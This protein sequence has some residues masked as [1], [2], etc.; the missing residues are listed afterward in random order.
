MPTV[1][2]DNGEALP[3]VRHKE[4]GQD[5]PSERGAPA[6]PADGAEKGAIEKDAYGV[7]G[8]SE[9]AIEALGQ[10][11][12][13]TPVADIESVTDPERHRHQQTIR[14]TIK[15]AVGLHRATKRIV[16]D[17]IALD[18]ASANA[19]E[20]LDEDDEVVVL[21]PATE[22]VIA[23]GPKR[24]VLYGLC[25][26]LEMAMKI[27]GFL[28]DTKLVCAIFTFS[29]AVT[30]LAMAK[31]VPYEFIWLGILG[32]PDMLR[33]FFKLNM[34]AVVLILHELDFWVPF[35]TLCLSL[36]F[37]SASFDNDMG[38]VLS[39]ILLVFYY[40]VNVL[41]GKTVIHMNCSNNA[42]TFE[43]HSISTCS[44]CRPNGAQGQEQA[45][46]SKDRPVHH[47]A[48][49]LDLVHHSACLRPFP[50]GK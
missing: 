46:W 6:I 35:G 21:M 15:R 18:E 28:E 27:N 26:D 23:H 37:G 9:E 17:A 7:H 31:V 5:W 1:P 44:R 34:E 12:E 16:F 32:L 45:P 50:W 11:E 38:V 25:G 42:F 24:T 33:K 3:P 39:S 36:G 19:I 4:A 29:G 43:P 47:H 49:V 41:L 8:S 22:F 14:Q 48:A 2:T 30:L 13:P 20:A 40:T 10:A